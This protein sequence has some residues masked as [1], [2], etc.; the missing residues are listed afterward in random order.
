[1]VQLQLLKYLLYFPLVHW[2]SVVEVRL[3]LQPSALKDCQNE[4]PAYNKSAFCA[5]EEDQY[6]SEKFHL[7]NIQ[8]LINQFWNSGNQKSDYFTF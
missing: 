6:D 4:P 2:Y 5:L 3:S 1:M 7:L 8:Q